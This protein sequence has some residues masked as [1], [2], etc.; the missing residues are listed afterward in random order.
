MIFRYQHQNQT[1]TVQIERVSEDEY[2]VTVEDRVYQVQGS[3]LSEHLWQFMIG[4][5]KHTAHIA[6]DRQRRWV[7]Q[8]GRSPVILETVEPQTAQSRRR[9]RGS[10]GDARLNAQMPGQVVD[11]LVAV[12]DNVTE[13]QTLLI[14]EAMKMEIRVTAPYDGSVQ[15]VNVSKGEVVER[16][17]PLIEIKAHTTDT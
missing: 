10:A 4:S 6:A 14:L 13:G 17:Q 12:G 11:V 9:N 15:Q 8:E 16:D 2:R 3:A 5:Q 7:Q 1:Y